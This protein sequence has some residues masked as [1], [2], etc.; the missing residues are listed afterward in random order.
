VLRRPPRDVEGENF[1]GIPVKK[2][3]PKNK[4][5]YTIKNTINTINIFHYNP[6]YRIIVKYK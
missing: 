3:N 6:K 5:E 2:G 1:P 4:I